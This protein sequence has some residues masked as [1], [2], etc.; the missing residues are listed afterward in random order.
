MSTQFRL[1][2]L[3][4]NSASPT[5]GRFTSSQVLELEGQSYLI[6]CGEGAQIRMQQFGIKKSKIDQIFISHL[7]G[8]H[9]NGLIGFLNSLALNG[10]TAP[11]QVFAPIGLEGLLNTY[12]ALTGGDVDDVD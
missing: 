9:I 7:H 8:D 4:T 6:D 3:G 12:N 1:T 2:L 10:R 11:M 5:P